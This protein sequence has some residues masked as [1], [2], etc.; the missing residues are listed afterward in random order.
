M[1]RYGFSCVKTCPP[2]QA[3][4]TS[5]YVINEISQTCSEQAVKDKPTPPKPAQQ[6]YVF[7][8]QTSIKEQ[9]IGLIVDSVNF[10][11]RYEHYFVDDYKHSMMLANKSDFKNPH[12]YDRSCAFKGKMIEKLSEERETYFEC[13]CPEAY[14]PFCEVSEGLYRSTNKFVGEVLK[15][16]E[17][18]DIHY[19]PAITV[20]KTLQKAFLSKDNLDRISFLL[21]SLRDKSSDS[22]DLMK[23]LSAVDT[24]LIS[25]NELIKEHERSK[26]DQFDISNQ[27]AIPEI[28]EQIEDLLAYSEDSVKVEFPRMKEY[29]STP[30]YSFQN[31]LLMD[32]NKIF[33]TPIFLPTPFIML[34]TNNKHN[35]K[36]TVHADT[37]QPA[38]KEYDIGAS[39]WSLSTELFREID[40]GFFATNVIKIRFYQEK[41]GKV[42]NFEPALS[43][44]KGLH[45]SLPL[46]ITPPQE[47][48]K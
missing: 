31:V 48:L 2:P 24:T 47:N 7:T 39:F 22:F 9:S 43:S 33:N 26:S 23:Y 42:E 44:S 40:Q 36:V 4:K 5:K 12:N 34:T 8:R 29:L 35:I 18:S 16:L 19:K 38:F 3:N 45:I 20:I 46:R 37:N 17:N 27:R 32:A 41:N 6:G 28:H 25:Y 15:E 21:L 11:K 13:N 10:I 30:T 1:R 14:G